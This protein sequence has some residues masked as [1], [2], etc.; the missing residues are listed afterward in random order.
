VVSGSIFL[1]V[2]YTDPISPSFFCIFGFVLFCYLIEYFI[3]LHFTCYPLSQSPPPRIL[4]SHPLAPASMRVSPFPPTPA[5][6][7]SN[8]PTLEHQAFKGPRAFPPIDD[9]QSHPLL[10]IWLEPWVPACELLG[11]WFRPWELWLVDTV[12]AMGLQ[13]PSSSSSFLYSIG[14]PVLSP[15][16]DCKHQPLYMSGT[17]RASLQK[18]YQA[19]FSRHF[20]ASTVVSAFGDYMGWIP[21]W[22]SC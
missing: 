5:F 22:S 9:Q 6:L 3:Y 10:H 11:W 14:D 12:L 8:S 21:R 7:P 17:G 20:L 19:P 18:L 1:T 13:T 15:V 16:V 4:L 2:K